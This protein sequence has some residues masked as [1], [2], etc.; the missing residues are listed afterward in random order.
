MPADFESAL[1]FEIAS[2]EERRTKLTSELAR[3]DGQLNGLQRALGLYL[4][5]TSVPHF[6]LMRASRE[7][8]APDPAKSESWAF[9]LRLLEDAP[10]SGFSVDEI[11]EHCAESG[12]SVARNTLLAN[13]SNAYRDGTIQRVRTGHYRKRTN[14]S[15]IPTGREDRELHESSDEKTQPSFGYSERAE[16]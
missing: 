15:G 14:G 16:S 1:R 2:L 11:A 3:I 4:G 12:Y 7:A 6:A 9:I 13:L 10:E 5:E 8:K